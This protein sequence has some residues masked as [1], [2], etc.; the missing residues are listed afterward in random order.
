MRGRYIAEE[1]VNEFKLH[2]I[3]FKQKEINCKDK[4]DFIQAS[5]AVTNSDLYQLAEM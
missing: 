1:L 2:N 5:T 4:E 3:N